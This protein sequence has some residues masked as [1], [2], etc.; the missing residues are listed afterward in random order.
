[1]RNPESGPAA[2]WRAI[3][4]GRTR[5]IVFHEGPDGTIS[6]SGKRGGWSAQELCLD[7]KHCGE[8]EEGRREG[9]QE[10]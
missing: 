3:E 6:L 9:G 7:G 5:G 4:A 8:E 2:V 10:R 1:M